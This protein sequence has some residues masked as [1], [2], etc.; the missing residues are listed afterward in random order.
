MFN[1]IFPSFERI[2][3]SARTFTILARYISPSIIFNSSHSN[4][5][6]NSLIT[7]ASTYLLFVVVNPAFS[8]LSGSLFADTIPT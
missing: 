8:I 7:G 5:I 1:V 2:L 4:A 3:S 6:G